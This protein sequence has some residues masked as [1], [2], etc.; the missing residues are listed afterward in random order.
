MHLEIAEGVL[1]DW[2]FDTVVKHED[3]SEKQPL[4]RNLTKSDAT[5]NP[6]KS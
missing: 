3:I 5:V 2:F 4:G 1:T 6:E